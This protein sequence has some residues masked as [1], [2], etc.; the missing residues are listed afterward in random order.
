MKV[1]IAIAVAV[2]IAIGALAASTEAGGLGPTLTVAAASATH[3][4]PCNRDDV[5]TITLS[6]TVNPNGQDTSWHFEYGST[7]A[8]DAQTATVDAGSGTAAVA[9]SAHP[10]PNGGGELHFRLAATSAGGTAHSDDQTLPVQ[11]FNCPA[12]VVASP[13][14]RS[15]K[16]N[17][18]WTLVSFSRRHRRAVIRF[19]P[20]CGV[21][22]APARTT[23][24]R[25]RHHRVQ[26]AVTMRVGLPASSCITLTAPQRA[27][28][29]VPPGTSAAQII[30]AKAS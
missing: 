15:V 28:V 7:T 12:K 27:T 26:I 11:V 29:D 19:Q 4:D 13:T 25:V 10:A 23:V 16:T 1:T 5:E 2:L 30:H 24:T 6:G 22:S 3:T 14:A 20:P 9:V 18:A 21:T 17:V 8:Y